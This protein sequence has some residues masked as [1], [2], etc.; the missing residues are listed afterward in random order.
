VYLCLYL[1]IDLICDVVE[2]KLFVAGAEMV[3]FTLVKKSIFVA[4]R[5]GTR[6]GIRSTT[7]EL[8]SNKQIE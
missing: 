6:K 2:T 4:L 3:V 8:S 7:A 5:S 1:M